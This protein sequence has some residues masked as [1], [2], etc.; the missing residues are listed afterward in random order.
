MVNSV[1]FLQPF[2][3][4]T[5]ENVPERNGQHRVEPEPEK[6]EESANLLQ[7]MQIIKSV[8]TVRHTPQEILAAF[9]NKKSN[10]RPIPNAVVQPPP[11][12]KSKSP[13][14]A[15][16]TLVATPIEGR[17]TLQAPEIPVNPPCHVCP[18]CGEKC[19]PP[20]P[21]PSLASKGPELAQRV[22]ELRIEGETDLIR[23]IEDHQLNK[24]N[25]EMLGAVTRKQEIFN[26]LALELQSSG[27]LSPPSIVDSYRSEITVQSPGEGSSSPPSP[28]HARCDDGHGE[29][30][31]AEPL[32][33]LSAKNI[34]ASLVSPSPTP[35]PER[36][37]AEIDELSNECAKTQSENSADDE[38]H[39]VPS[40]SSQARVKSSESYR[41]ES[42]SDS[43]S[44]KDMPSPNSRQITL[45][46]P[47][48]VQS[49]SLIRPR[50]KSTFPPLSPTPA[51]IDLSLEVP[52]L[53]VIETLKSSILQDMSIEP[54]E[55]RQP[56]DEELEPTQIVCCL[57]EHM[58]HTLTF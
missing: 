7:V 31:A 9:N 46:A 14:K 20:Y 23:F 1:P 44:T 16:P 43:P 39:V 48:I 10:R 25:P 5:R 51:A 3:S 24:R 49:A 15:P 8:C 28:A 41:S 21:C 12:Q 45:A 13:N 17:L 40:V 26:P 18:I 53:P 19:H 52:E 57:L 4:E 34:A 6:E 50:F 36:P 35:I 11:A 33:E 22:Q 30:D 29:N 47:P 38:W 37:P 42:S 2:A 58:S 56:Q 27:L 32:L 54:G 55:I